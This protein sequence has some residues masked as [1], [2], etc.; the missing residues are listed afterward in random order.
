M[1][2]QVGPSGQLTPTGVEPFTLTAEQ[3]RFFATFGFLALP[4]LFR[5]EISRLTDGFEQVFAENPTWDTKEEL[6][7][8]QRRSIIPGIVSKSADL[9]WLLDDHRIVGIT[10][11]L[12]GPDVQYAESDGNLFFCETSWHADNY[13]APLQQLHVKLSFYLDPLDA[14]SGAIR[15]IP[16]TNFWETE[17]ASALRRDLATPASTLEAYGV[18]WDEIPSW[19]L[20]TEPGDLVVWNFRTVHASFNGGLRRRLFSLNYCAP[21]DDAGGEPAATASDLSAPS[22]TA[23]G[24]G[25]SLSARAASVGP[26]VSAVGGLVGSA[27]RRGVRRARRLRASVRP[28]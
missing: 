8:D 28:G 22:G 12:V 9:A 17:F 23:R 15:L 4:G 19:P 21:V 3:R 7:F 13:S 24:S 14:E 26:T 18:R 1:A 16:G 27:A 10:R 5:A 2:I 11:G 25:T 6:H 20:S